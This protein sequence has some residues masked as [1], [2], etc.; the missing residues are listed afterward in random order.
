[1]V[2]KEPHELKHGDHIFVVGKDYIPR[3]GDDI[4]A[5]HNFYWITS[6]PGINCAYE[7]KTTKELNFHMYNP[8]FLSFYKLE[9]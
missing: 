2:K 5:E 8:A 3:P 9:S 6:I 4:R 1:M 7:G